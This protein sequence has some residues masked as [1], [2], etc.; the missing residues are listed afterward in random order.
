MSHDPLAEVIRTFQDDAE[1]ECD[2]LRNCG[3]CLEDVLAAVRGHLAAV[4]AA[5]RKKHATTSSGR[6]AVDNLQAALQVDRG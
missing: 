6:A 3:A 2:G 5:E 4:L 1:G